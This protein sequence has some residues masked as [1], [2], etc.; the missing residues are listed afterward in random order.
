MRLIDAD[1]II[2]CFDP[3]TWQGE[4]MIAIA[5]N[6][7]TAYDVDAVVKELESLAEKH[8]AISEKSAELGKA[9][10]N[11]TVLNGGKGI[12]YENAIEIV[13]K[14]GKK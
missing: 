1:E 11:H 7:P 14:G 5:E 9:Y 12:A 3:E 13:R 4:M 6:L 8:M 2:K 10:E